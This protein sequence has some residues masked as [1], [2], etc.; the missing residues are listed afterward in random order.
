MFYECMI[1]VMQGCLIS[2]QLEIL[3]NIVPMQLSHVI[4]N[5]EI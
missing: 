1:Q 4:D 5:W 3:S 2:C